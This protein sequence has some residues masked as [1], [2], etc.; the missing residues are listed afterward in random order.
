MKQAT[1][2]GI[3]T[4]PIIVNRADFSQQTIADECP[5]LSWLDDASRYADCTPEEVTKY[6]EEDEARLAD[7]GN[8]WDMV[9]IRASIELRIPAGGGVSILQTIESPGLWGIESDSGNS[10]FADVF[11]EECNTLE[12]MLKELHVC[13][14]KD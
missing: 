10:Y 11:E 2:K 3:D 7:Y 14:L 5:D 8:G 1:N 9:G 6:K 12:T 13:V 4:M